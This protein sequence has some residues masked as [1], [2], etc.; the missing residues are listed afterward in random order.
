MCSPLTTP[1]EWGLKNFEPF[2]TSSVTCTFKHYLHTAAYIP[3]L[4][5]KHLWVWPVFM[6]TMNITLTVLIDITKKC[7]FQLTSNECKVWAWSVTV[8]CKSLPSTHLYLYKLTH[9]DTVTHTLWSKANQQYRNVVI[10]SCMST[11]NNHNCTYRKLRIFSAPG[12]FALNNQNKNLYHYPRILAVPISQ[13]PQCSWWG[14]VLAKTCPTQWV[15]LHN[16]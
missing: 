8:Q 1:E 4:C 11:V 14:L 3:G 9:N 15:T 13:S 16:I 10:Q 2:L 12:F 5:T 7:W 6:R